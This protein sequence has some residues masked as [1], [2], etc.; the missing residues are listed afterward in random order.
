MYWQACW[1][2]SCWSDGSSVSSKEK[3]TYHCTF[4]RLQHLLTQSISDRTGLIPVSSHVGMGRF[5]FT[6]TIMTKICCSMFLP[7]STCHDTEAL[8]NV[9]A[10]FHVVWINCYLPF[11][12]STLTMAN[13]ILKDIT[14]PCS[15][16][17]CGVEEA[18]F[19]L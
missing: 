17:F 3:L 16:L 8:R 5:L 12:N 4:I 19:S 11:L 9:L 10:F 1:L 6:A 15:F 13:G 2:F 14:F 18:C 7:I